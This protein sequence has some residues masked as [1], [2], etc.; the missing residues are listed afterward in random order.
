LIHEKLSISCF[1]NNAEEKSGYQILAHFADRFA[2]CFCRNAD[3]VSPN[4]HR[5][6]SNIMFCAE[7]NWINFAMIGV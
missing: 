7:K 1:E 2:G 4:S 6:T 3:G 5:N